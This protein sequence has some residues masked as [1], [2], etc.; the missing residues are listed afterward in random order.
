MTLLEQLRQD[1]TN[2]EEWD[3]SNFWSSDFEKDKFD[4]YH[5]FKGTTPTN[6]PDAEK[7]VIFATGK[8]LELAIVDRLKGLDL[9]EPVDK[10]HD[11]GE[12]QTR[13]EMERCGTKITGKLDSIVK[14]SGK[15]VPLEIKSFYG[16]QQAYELMNGKPRVSYL[17]Q[18]AS[19]MDALE[20]PKGILLYMDRGTGAMYQ[21][22]LVHMDNYN[23]SCISRDKNGHPV[24]TKFNLLKDYERFAEIYKKYIKPDKEPESDFQY[25][26]DIEQIDWDN[27]SKDKISKARTGKAVL[28][29]WQ[30]KYSPFKDILIQREAERHG[31]KF[32][33]Y[34]GYSDEEIARICEITKGYSTKKK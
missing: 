15:K 16:P 21:F 13:I 26:Y 20:L 25:K 33:D 4:L 8:L 32:E 11:D 29:D 24:E 27:L 12:G 9:I 18:L 34:I 31:K 22:D 17:K 1:L 2:E 10:E 3:K 5:R 23:Y 14:D 19:Y 7:Q 6:P 28:G 30:A